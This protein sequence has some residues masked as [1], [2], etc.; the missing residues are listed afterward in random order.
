MKKRKKKHS[1]KRKINIQASEDKN[2]FNDFQYW[3]Y[4]LQSLSKKLD[5]DEEVLKQHIEKKTTIL[6][7]SSLIISD[8]IWLSI[9][10]Y[11][12]NK[13]YMIQTKIKIA[14]AKKIKTGPRSKS[15]QKKKKMGGK[16]TPYFIFGNLY[17]TIS[18]P[19]GT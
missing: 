19:M 18:T 15:K 7:N 4:T 5:I 11:V 6:Y 17:K 3:N 12:L 14:N 10:D 2:Y 8:E 9:K 16:P 1:I 13:I